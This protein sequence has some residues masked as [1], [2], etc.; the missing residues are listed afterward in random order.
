[1]IYAPLWNFLE[2]V[3]WM[4]LSRDFCPFWQKP[5][6]QNTFFFVYVQT[7]KHHAFTLMQLLKSFT[8]LSCSHLLFKPY[9]YTSPIL[10]SLSYLL[11]T[12]LTSHFKEWCYCSNYFWPLV[13]LTVFFSVISVIGK[14]SVSIFCRKHIV[15]GT[16]YKNVAQGLCNYVC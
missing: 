13:S 5:C 12:F 3:C 9:C 6:G 10:Y 15:L 2:N 4:S 8:H 16:K 14:K 7:L 1:M 11:N